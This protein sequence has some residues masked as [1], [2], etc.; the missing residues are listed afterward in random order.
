[1]TGPELSKRIEA[2]SRL[3]GALAKVSDGGERIPCIGDPETWDAEHPELQ[4]A[5]VHACGVCDQF[6]ACRRYVT[7]YLEPEGIWAGL[8]PKQQTRLHREEA[9]R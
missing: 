4:E 9:N 1:M 2:H 7:A 3:M 6:N 5:A 8:T